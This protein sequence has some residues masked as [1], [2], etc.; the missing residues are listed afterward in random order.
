MKN[1]LEQPGFGAGKL[2]VVMG[3]KINSNPAQGAINPK[4]K[5]LG[6]ND[7]ESLRDVFFISTYLPVRLRLG[8]KAISGQGL[9]CG[10]FMG[11]FILYI[12]YCI[13]YIGGI[14]VFGLVRGFVC[15]V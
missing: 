9:A 2:F 1:D 13:L 4:A 15:E 12:L 7:F 3:I 5:A 10:V 6:L 14:L 8:L 11:D